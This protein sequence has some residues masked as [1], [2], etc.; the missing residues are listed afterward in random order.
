M[1]IG[2]D[3]GGTFT[4]FVVFE[5]GVGTLATFK[6][7]STPGDPA[8]AVLEGLSRVRSSKDA[9]GSEADSELGSETDSELE[10]DPRAVSG[11]GTLRIVH[12]ST[13][14]TNA[15]LERRGAPTAL[16]TTRGFRDVLRIGRQ[17]RPALYDLRVRRAEPLV[18]PE[19]CFEV[20]E[21]VDR[22]GEVIL[23]LD[24]E[25]VDRLVRVLRET[26]AESV[27][28]SLLFSFARPEHEERVAER[29]R[30]EGF[31]VSASSHVLPE[32]REYERASTTVLDAYVTPVLD[33]Y[34]GRLEQE[35]GGAELRIMLSN[36]GS[37]RAAEARRQGVRSV[38][39][40]PAGGVVG[41]VRVARAAGL[42]KVITFDMGG[43][44]T[45]VSLADGEPRLTAEGEL[46]GVPV[47]VPI[48]DLHTV[49]SGGGSVAYVDTG[50]AL[51]VGP[52][53]AGAD[54]GPTCYGRGGEEP[55]VTD[56]N[57]VLGRLPAD[58][59]LGGAMTLD[60]GAAR[61]AL[62]RLAVEAGIEGGPDAGD[63]LNSAER[64]ALGVIRV[65]EAHMERALRVISVERG[66]DP[67]DFALVSFGGAGG[68]HATR[69]A[70]ALGIGRVLVPPEASTLSALGMLLAPVARDYVLTV[71]LPGDTSHQKLEERL[72]PLR[73]RGR[74]DLRA[75]GVGEEE[76]QLR[77]ELDV[78]YAGQSWELSVP[79]TADYLERFHAVHEEAYGHADRGAAV[80]VVNLRL[81]AWGALP[82]P[83]LPEGERG[84]PHP[85]AAL[86]DRRPV[87]V[88][89]CRCEVPFYLAERLQPGHRVDGP[90]V[91][92]RSDT[93]VLLEPGDR[94]EVDRGFRLLIDTEAGDEAAPTRS[95]R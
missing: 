54:P 71:M 91:V 63:D 43:T 67:A 33:R 92:V 42:E 58:R 4:D 73:E 24:D 65:A 15:V 16:V 95:R 25:E 52:R 38:L 9:F 76:A 40:G 64:A 86:L 29:L 88:G 27:A 19:R 93:T 30:R 51:R 36:G 39:S 5:P 23:P 49:G 10:L 66:H 13:V 79:L 31:F 22:R 46:A 3:I 17:A 35:L 47:R 72:R 87:V 70:R 7:L 28:V 84:P 81:R 68:L 57:L 75:E 83:R 89:G 20:D 48:V 80:E 85:S 61:A 18:P 12:G 69:L 90:A 77:A 11:S 56:A 34:L 37:A 78:R 21:R 32:F 45:D 50:G 6:V 8:A 74:S 62:E 53:S 2:I 82:V 60:M 44:S 94:A 1:R 59:F 26:G 55:T 41:A 14:A